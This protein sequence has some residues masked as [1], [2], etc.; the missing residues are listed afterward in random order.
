MERA[1]LQFSKIIKARVHHFEVPVAHPVRTSFGDMTSRH[2]VLLELTDQDGLAGFG[3][4]WVNYPAWA[5]A[6]RVA[7]FNTAFIPFLCGRAIDDIPGFMMEMMKAFR[8]PALQSG[9]MGPLL[10]ALCAIE[11]ALLE[12]AA[13]KKEVSVSKLL[14][15]QP[16][17][18]VK[19]YCSG[20][21]APL[22]HQLIEDHLQRGVSLFK[23]K[24]GFGD[25]EDARN[26][27]ELKQ[28]LG[29]KAKIAVDVNR[30][31]TF[32][33]AGWWLKKLAD[34]EVQWLEEPLRVEEASR[35]RELSLASEIPIAGGENIPVEPGADMIDFADEPVAILQPDMTKYCLVHSFLRLLPEASRRGKS[36]VPHFLGAAPG[37]AFSA[38]LAAGCSGEPLVEWDINSNPLHTDFFAEPFQISDGM[39]DIPE[40]PGLGWTP[41]LDNKYRV[42]IS[43]LCHPYG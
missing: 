11:M 18:R 25:A 41:I 35:A 31:W 13:R 38:Q 6:E 1:R 30:K 5:A 10:S 22:P 37:Q 43:R 12:L 34:L 33:Q 23:L 3:E 39:L 17:T 42:N 28:L 21:N 14:F 26:L 36:V 8:G 4:S 24:L 29:S 32:A 9:T 15:Q 20:I 40:R 16:A 7:A 2:L 19:V 27:I